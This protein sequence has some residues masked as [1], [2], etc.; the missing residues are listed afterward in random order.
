MQY[1]A[2]LSIINIILLLAV[3]EFIIIAKAVRILYYTWTLCHVQY[4]AVLSII[5]II[6]LLAVLEFIIIAKAV[7]IL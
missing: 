4:C 7:R 2:V 3:L 1:C 5:N 6:L